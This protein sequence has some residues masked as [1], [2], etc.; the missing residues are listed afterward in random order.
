MPIYDYSCNQCGTR[1][2][3]RLSFTEKD[4]GLVPVC[5]NCSSS[6]TR[7]IIT[8]GMGLL[9]GNSQSGNDLPPACGPRL[10]GGCCGG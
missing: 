6:E 8:G 1:F 9:M 2:E 4:S 5:P 7:Q 3:T 10:G